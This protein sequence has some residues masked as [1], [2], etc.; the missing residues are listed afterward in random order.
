MRN[1]LYY[2]DNLEILQNKVRD[3]SVHLCYIDPPFNS[4][5]NWNQIYNKVGEDDPAQN[6]VFDDTWSWTTRTHDA[7]SQIL[8]NHLGRFTS[9]TIE[10]VQALRG[11]LGQDSGLFAYLVSITLRLA[12]IHRVLVPSGC[13]YLHCDPTASHYLKMIAD[14]IFVRQGGNFLNEIV[15]KRAHTVKGNFGQGSKFFGPNT[16][17]ILFYSKSDGHKFNPVF[18]GYSEDY[19]KKF[20]RYSEVDGRRYR[21]IS[22]IGPGGA[23][24]GNPQYEFMG[25]TRYWRYSKQRMAELQKAGMIVQN[26]PGRV[27]QR[28]QYLDNGKGV[29]CQSL[30][31]D[32]QALSPTAEERVGYPTQK[33]AALLERIIFASSNEGDVVLDAYCGCGTTVAVAQAMNRRWIGIDVTYEAIATILRRLEKKFGAEFVK[34]IQLDGIPRDMKSAIA[35]AHKKDDRP[36]KEFEKWAILTYTAN[37]A[38]VNQKKGADRGIDGIFYFWN[39]A[40]NGQVGKMI[41]QVKSGAVHR[42]DIATLRGDMERDQA[43]LGCLITLEEPTEAMSREA[44]SAGIYDNKARGIKCDRIRMVRVEDLILKP[45]RLELPLHSDASDTALREVEG[46]QLRLDLRPPEPE[47]AEEYKERQKPLLR[48]PP[49][50]AIPIK[51]PQ[52]PSRV[53]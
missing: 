36:R 40:H 19:L 50:R 13:F 41:L 53:A 5:R 8:S 48:K 14:S 17:T 2:G 22:M 52:R 20:Y 46:N 44:K 12:E 32:I 47:K 10:L 7:C 26:K 3:E 30:W 15:W 18:S 25:V 29:A 39:G 27:P 6:Q 49:V 31:D 43:A 21:L 4:K 16:D 28:K 34:S 24:K 33:P 11:V 9:H 51:K 42:N 37:R 45:E 1:C 23:A 38:V 35:L